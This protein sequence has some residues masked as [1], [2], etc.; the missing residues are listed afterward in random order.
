MAFIEL[1]NLDDLRIGLFV[2]LECSWWNHPF[3]KN[4]FKVQSLKEIK[5]IRSIKKLKLFYDPALSSPLPE[6][7]PDSEDIPLPIISIEAEEVD[8]PSFEEVEETIEEKS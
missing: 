3:T 7:T 5:T 8:I 6:E 4:T 1:T 2:K